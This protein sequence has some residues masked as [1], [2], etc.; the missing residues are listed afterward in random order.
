MYGKKDQ[1]VHYEMFNHSVLHKQCSKI[2][3]PRLVHSS[4]VFALGHA[5]SSYSMIRSPQCGQ[6][7]YQAL[8]SYMSQPRPAHKQLDDYIWTSITRLSTFCATS[9]PQLQNFVPPSIT[10]SSYHSEAI[11]INWDNAQCLSQ[12]RHSME[13]LKIRFFRLQIRIS[14]SR[15]TLRNY[16]ALVVRMEPSSLRTIAKCLTALTSHTEM[17]HDCLPTHQ[18]PPSYRRLNPQI[19]ALIGTHQRILL[20]KRTSRILIH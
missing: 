17:S 16:L 6:Q 12:A 20:Q 11:V 7:V 4:R 10:R 14:S 18:A 3:K 19:T 13:S 9:F 1:D 5:S 2:S 15:P 8:F